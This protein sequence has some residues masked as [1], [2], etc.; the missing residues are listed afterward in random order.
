MRALRSINIVGFLCLA[1]ATL[2]S[3][4]AEAARLELGASTQ[5]WYRNRDGFN[6]RFFAQPSN[7]SVYPT[8][9]GSYNDP[10]S[11]LI[12]YNSYFVFDVGTTDQRPITK[13]TLRLP[14]KQYFSSELSETIALFDVNTPAAD[15]IGTP[16][17]LENFEDLGS[18]EKFGSRTIEIANVLDQ[19]EDTVITRM[20]DIAL[21][22]AA[23]REIEQAIRGVGQFAIGA[24]LE[25]LDGTPFIFST[26][27]EGTEGLTFSDGQRSYPAQFSEETIRELLEAESPATLIL[28]TA[29]PVEP[30]GVPESSA[31]VGLGLLGL[32]WTLQRSRKKP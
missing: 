21:N 16:F 24:S 9:I 5:G 26:G 18:G 19:D 28:E 12:N 20:I 14:V 25:S 23:I 4:P 7:G 30:I 6:I 10:D 29:D 11:G 1:T 17:S 22:A 3:S 15:L 27:I 2:L 31:T 8:F 13:A 32:G